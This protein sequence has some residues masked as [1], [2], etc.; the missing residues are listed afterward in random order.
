MH[1]ALCSLQ[2]TFCCTDLD[3]SSFSSLFPSAR[4]S[5]ATLILFFISS[6]ESLMF[7]N[8]ACLLS[9]SLSPV[10]FLTAPSFCFWFRFWSKS[11]S[12]RGIAFFLQTLAFPHQ[13]L[14]PTKMDI[15]LYYLVPISEHLWW[16]NQVN[17]H[18]HQ[19]DNC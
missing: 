5:S 18:E 17:E 12:E 8:S 4:I 3:N 14:S 16:H 11:S 1:F 6:T 10:T 9:S 19:E 15:A 13:F 7:F 2:A